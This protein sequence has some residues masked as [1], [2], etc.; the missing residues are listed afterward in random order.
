MN[1]LFFSSMVKKIILGTGRALLRSG[2]FFWLP[3][4][5]DLSFLTSGGGSFLFSL[6]DGW[7][8]LFLLLDKEAFV[9][10]FWRGKL[11]FFTSGGGTFLFSL[12][13]GNLSFFTSDGWTFAFLTP[14]G[15]DFLFEFWR[16]TFLF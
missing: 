13:E 1:S 11:S 6:P 9:F 2:L 16:G 3:R 7:T 8:V 15:G 5:R 4:G 10:H 14:A 12:L